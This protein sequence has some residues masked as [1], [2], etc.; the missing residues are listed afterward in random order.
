MSSKIAIRKRARI[1]R[2]HHIRKV[3]NGTAERPRLVIYRSLHHMYAQ[4]VNDV[5]GETLMGVSSLSADLRPNLKGKNPSQVA[6][7]VGALC[8]EK[9]KAK[10][11]ESV[12]FDRNGFPYHGRVKAVAEA[13]RKAGLKF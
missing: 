10:S 2:K 4:L 11:I 12:V 13:A 8:A 3:V 1:R 9:A 6:E 5:T 7:L